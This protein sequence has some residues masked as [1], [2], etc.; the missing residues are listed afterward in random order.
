MGIW[1][2]AMMRWLGPAGRVMAMT[3]IA[4]PKRKDEAGQWHE[5]KVPDHVDILVN[6]KSGPVAHL[7][8]SSLTAMAPPP[9]AWIFG[10]EG[11][12]RVEVDAKR[13]TGGRRG[14]KELKEIAIPAEQRI[15][16]RVEEEFVSAI[17]GREKI[18]HTNF[19]DGVRYMEF[20]DA[21]AKSASSGQAVDV[22][23]GMRHVA[24]V[25]TITLLAL[26]VATAAAAQSP[27]TTAE[28]RAAAQRYVTT[29]PSES[30][31]D[32]MVATL[33]Q[34]VPSNRRE[35]FVTL[36]RK[37]VPIDAMQAVTIETMSR[38]FTVEEIDAMTRFQGSPEGKAIMG[39]LGAYMGE[40]MPQVQREVLRALEKAREEMRI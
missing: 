29:I 26:A 39:K 6:F 9:E 20:T 37:L 3:K 34:Q 35:E 25:T 30:V 36:M 11:T 4:T 7:R 2:E 22:K 8:F 38:H 21:V 24:R 27:D 19:E 40:L 13:L 31:F 5:V 33:S 14:D 28:R 32:E 18:T 23:V 10:S 1:Y 17:R 15:G 16:W 12:L